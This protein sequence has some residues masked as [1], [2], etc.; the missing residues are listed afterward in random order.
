MFTHAE[1]MEAMFDTTLTVEETREAIRLAFGAG[2]ATAAVGEFL[3][4]SRMFVMHAGA[5]RHVFGKFAPLLSPLNVTVTGTDGLFDIPVSAYAETFERSPETRVLVA[6]APCGAG[7]TNA[8]VSYANDAR[9][10][11]PV[12]CDG[13]VCVRALF[14][15]SRIA[16][17]E[18]LY[19]DMSRA[20]PWMRC[21]MY[22][23]TDAIDDMRGSPTS[24]LDCAI[25][26][27][28]H[29]LAAVLLRLVQGRAELEDLIDTTRRR[30]DGPIA[31]Y[32][33]VMMPVVLSLGCLERLRIGALIVDEAA[34]VIDGIAMGEHL[35]EPAVAWAVL[36]CAARQ[37]VQTVMMSAD[38]GESVLDF[39]TT[40]KGRSATHLLIH[41][42]TRERRV[43]SYTEP[44]DF[45]SMFAR[46]VTHAMTTGERTMV[47]CDNK[48]YAKALF[49]L[50]SKLNP[51]QLKCMLICAPSG[52]AVAK[53][54]AE[55]DV[56]CLGDAHFVIATP[57][58]A[59]AVS[60][61]QPIFS[62]LFGAFYGAVPPKTAAQLIARVRLMKPFAGRPYTWCAYV[63]FN[64]RGEGTFEPN[65]TAA[66]DVDMHGAMDLL[67]KLRRS[68][69]A[70][71]DTALDGFDFSTS[72]RM[73]YASPMDEFAVQLHR[74]MVARG[75]D[76][77]LARVLRM[78][79]GCPLYR[80]L[81]SS[82]LESPE[83]L[84]GAQWSEAVISLL[85]RDGYK[86][87]NGAA[88]EEQ[89][90]CERNLVHTLV[91]CMR[92]RVPGEFKGLVG[93]FRG[94]QTDESE[95]IRVEFTRA[96]GWT[97]FP[98]TGGVAQVWV[99]TVCGEKIDKCDA[100]AVSA[101]WHVRALEA[102]FQKETASRVCISHA[103]FRPFW[104]DLDFVVGGAY[105]RE[106]CAALSAAAG[107]Q[108]DQAD[109]AALGPLRV[110]EIPVEAAEVLVPESPL[111]SFVRERICTDSP[112]LKARAVLEFAP[113][114]PP[115]KRWDAISRIPPNG[116]T[117]NDMAVCVTTIY[118]SFRISVDAKVRGRQ[119]SKRFVVKPAE[120]SQV[121][122]LIET[123]VSRAENAGCIG[124]CPP[125]VADSTVY[126][127]AARARG[128][129][130][131]AHQGLHGCAAIV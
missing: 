30:A 45:W 56:T 69:H 89:T 48:G 15:A 110:W 27:T 94:D 55:G 98:D 43:L 112:G 91:R 10:P 81:V 1:L 106:L 87:A 90:A 67:D 86:L 21:V 34:S 32:A 39:A 2:A 108:A 130:A 60:I 22:T 29:S 16:E 84:R 62:F 19:A 33:G 78:R 95:R 14:V 51:A 74:T 70:R 44:R 122:A 8:V 71:R 120:P 117:W 73:R 64:T 123:L 12:V 13:R 40:A 66:T 68:Y 7:K 49:D 4:A 126:R 52:R 124:Q 31:R 129:T 24:A 109:Q 59:Q 50:L 105:L 125:I 72:D 80:S 11:V 103:A 25:F 93:A 41:V 42:A 53:R 46:A 36:E 28:Y 17:V 76:P 101:V 6:S 113:S 54:L 47:V 65:A 61:V 35:A 88:A 75:A 18:K 121:D 20:C 23:E 79:Q 107:D 111:L 37:A 102:C 96:L 127:A 99:E 100:S 9:F 104:Y 97:K 116:V 118:A 114:S 77:R 83:R 63:L 38:A 115:K 85:E 5:R 92:S 128:M 58:V 26:T 3:C 57:V 119:N 82:L 131:W